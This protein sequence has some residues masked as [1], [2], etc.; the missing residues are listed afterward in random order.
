MKGKE[1]AGSRDVPFGDTVVDFV[2]EGFPEVA[3]DL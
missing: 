2:E 1:W 3:Y